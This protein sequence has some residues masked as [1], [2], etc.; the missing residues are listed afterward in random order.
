MI[1][2]VLLF[3]ELLLYGLVQ[4]LR[5]DFQ[6]LITKQDE[7]PKLDQDGLNRFYAK[8]FDPDLGWTRRPNT[9]G[10]E[11]G[12]SGEVSYQIDELGSRLNENCGEQP[13]TIACFG[14]SYAFC[15]QVE[16][17]ET[18]EH[19]LSE[20][21]GTCVLNFGV[22]NYGLDQALL[23]YRLT[24]LPKSI[25]TIV[26]AFVPET[27]CRIQST[28]KHYLEFG[29][30]F[31]F[32]PRYKLSE[33]GG[34]DLI[35]NPMQ[36]RADF[37]D[38]ERKLDQIIR[39]DRFYVGKFRKF[40]FRFPYT[41]SFMRNLRRNTNLISRLLMRE[42]YRRSGRIDPCVEDA[43]FEYIM[44]EN[45]RIAHQLY[46]DEQSVAL[47]TSLIK[48]FLRLAESRNHKAYVLILPQLIDLRIMA[49]N[50]SKTFSDVLSILD[51]P[52]GVLLDFTPYFTESEDIEQLYVNDKYGG[53]I[54]NR[55]NKYVAEKLSQVISL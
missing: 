34:L 12:E 38:Y 33:D 30:T 48:K 6:W 5:K 54:S 53:H 20:N 37:N 29:N 52:E 23:R 4:Y 43:P 14:D 13:P 17:S 42:V 10:I 44:N 9:R 31:A 22:G 50:N 49:K 51:I 2:L 36:N 45:I 32:K 35:P 41:I 11:K 8:S 18:W 15:R 25:D 26:M 16:D 27:I 21:L 3:M 28:W 1:I 46:Q 39:H 7:N 24:E 47:F 55:G 19:Y 40:Q